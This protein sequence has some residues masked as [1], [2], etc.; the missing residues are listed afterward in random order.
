MKNISALA[1]ALL[2]AT[3]G[4]GQAATIGVWND[5]QVDSYAVGNTTR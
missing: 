5:T 3:A 1:V 2:V 4:A